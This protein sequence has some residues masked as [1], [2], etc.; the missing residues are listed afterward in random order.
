VTYPLSSLPALSIADH[1]LVRAA[2][3]EQSERDRLMREIVWLCIDDA[4]AI[5]AWADGDVRRLRDARARFLRGHCF[6]D[7]E[8]HVFGDS[9][10]L[11]VTRAGGGTWVRAP[12]DQAAGPGNRAQRRAEAAKRR[13]GL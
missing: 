9:P 11:G 4:P 5:L 8:W 1:P 3:E 13:R 2:L 7:G 10:I 12:K 6:I